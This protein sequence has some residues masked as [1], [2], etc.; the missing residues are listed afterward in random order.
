[1]IGASDEPGRPNTGVTNHLR[2]WA[3]SAGATVYPVN[4][5]RPEVGGLV[6]YP[7][8]ADIPDEIDLAVIVVGDALSALG[9]AIE[10]KAK[11]AVIFSAGFAEVGDEGRLLQTKLEDLVAGSDLHLLG[12]NTNL[13]AFEVFRR[14]LPGRRI[15]LITQSGH[16]G[17]PLFQAQQIGV[18]LHAWAPTGNE[19]D[20]EFA[21]FARYF[22]DQSQVGAIAAYTEGFK[23][24]RTFC[25]AA[26]HAART[27]VPIV[28]VKVGRTN[29]GR[30][31]ALSH[32]AHLTGRDGV[33]NGVFRQFGV[34]R[35]EGL[36]Q[37]LD[38]SVMLARSDAPTS[39]GTSK[40]GGICIYSISGGTSA[41]ACDM[42]ESIGLPVPTLSEETQRQLHEW[43]PPYLRVSNP[44]D[45]GGHPVADWR[46]RRILDAIM[47]DPNVDALVCP[48]TGAF[49]PHSDQLAADLA[50]VAASTDK[51]VCVIWGSPVADEAAYRDTLLGSDR[52]VVFTTFANCLGAVKAWYDHHHFQR[53]YRS[54]FDRP[55]PPKRPSAAARVARPILAA[56]GRGRA[57][58][59]HNA[60]AVL[61]AY[62]IPVS[63][64]VLVTSAADA[65]RAVT[66]IGAPVVMKAC[67]AA[68]AHK[69]E[70]GLVRVGVGSATE[71]RRV[72]HQL[73][74]A[75]GDDPLDGVL[76]CELVQ[77]GVETVVGVVEDELFGKA[78][79]V[80][81]GGV[82]V[83]VFE[84]TAF[85]V[86][87]FDAS[88]AR[89]MVDELR[90]A[91]LLRGVRGAKP[92]N[93][94]ALVAVLMAVQRLAVD[95][96][97]D[98][99]ELD[100]NPLLCRPDGCVALD[101][102]MVTR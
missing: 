9:D 24:G 63:R 39:L 88:E 11:F 53:R 81:L 15:A 99:A 2:R 23:D 12:P 16:Q 91:T 72:Y 32:T 59:E 55:G 57:L 60:K 67:S 64:D 56:A 6:S 13:N 89:R 86:P 101:A 45:N 4:P 18:A 30:A 85:R 20:L 14:D 61:A 47:A 100:I 82:L 3:E 97:G 10:K 96:D 84:D 26:D 92:A 49:P 28:M 38:T 73:V 41:H 76:V 22:A 36:D 69:S 90:A 94:D 93:I 95:L 43:I 54:P 40:P 68:I 74:E 33:I 71:A 62:G 78:V 37:L 70:R 8:I 87:P 80:G 65:A 75:A 31:M 58:N 1:M 48:I 21:D 52:L 19:S 51:P 66:S 98:L 77:G 29:K 102:L 46:G 27:G 7:S 44:V 25:L 83:E 34:I 42:A 79:M 50:A 5:K 17:R 35:V